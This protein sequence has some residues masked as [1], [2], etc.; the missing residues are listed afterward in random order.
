[1]S[2]TQLTLVSL[3]D[4]GT[5]G[6][7]IVPYGAARLPTISRDGKTYV[8]RV[9]RG[10]R[11][12]DGSRLTARN[13]VAGLERLLDPRIHSQRAFLFD[14]ISGAR[15][16]MSGKAAH[17]TGVA[18][19][20]DRLV[21]HLA[22]PAPDIV[23]RLALP[24]MTAMPLDLPIV[25]GG[26]D[27]PLPSAG[28]YYAKE[29]EPGRAARLVRNPYWNAATMPSR[30][31]NVD[32]IQ[33][34]GR[35]PADAVDAVSRGDADVATFASP[36]TLPPD[37][38]RD[39]MHRYGVNRGRF[40]AR[41][42]LGR[43]SVIFSV[44]R[45]LFRNNAKLRRAVNF[46]LNRTELVGAH[47]PLAGQ[48]T[49]Q[50]LLPGRPG[51]HEWKLYPYKGDIVVAKRLARGALRG[52]DVFLYVGTGPG[53]SGP[54]VA[55]VIRSNLAPLGLRV[56]VKT[57]PTALLFA[58]LSLARTPW[59]LTVAG[60]NP[61]HDDPVPFIN[62][63]LDGQ[64]IARPF[65]GFN[66][67]RFNEPEW[68]ARMRRVASM[69]HGRDAAYARLDRDLMGTAAPLAPYLAANTVTIVSAR[70][71]CMS[72]LSHN[73]PNLARLCIK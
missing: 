27:A 38:V 37:L 14:D 2:A 12:S 13:F 4:T 3:R 40:F 67:G 44:R 53:S 71:G 7:R 11:F 24:I 21:I 51:F 50:L 5:R 18:V 52:K 23:D 34:L 41:P 57:L 28:P 25:P 43:V 62:F 55:A 45:P 33:Y 16:F 19:R 69:R 68:N 56:H 15:A 35:A 66:L 36:E 58:A 1:M 47:G 8:F 31:A 39:L 70:V 6:P 20:D 64:H 22:R 49:D 17:V 46:A 73:W 54:A 32:E 61:S 48:P 72:W 10:L 65:P 60:W 42:R 29:Y 63:A 59:D 9:R 30:P 26:V